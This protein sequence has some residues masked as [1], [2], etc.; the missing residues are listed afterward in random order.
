MFYTIKFWIRDRYYAWLVRQF[1]SLPRSIQY[2]YV[3]DYL[4]KQVGRGEGDYLKCLI[5]S[6][7]KDYLNTS[8]D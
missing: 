6:F 7:E 4:W 3:E 8:E 5:E 1:K 2:H